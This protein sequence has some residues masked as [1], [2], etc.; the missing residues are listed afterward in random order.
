MISPHRFGPCSQVEPSGVSSEGA[1][2]ADTFESQLT[3]EPQ[4]LPDM[5]SGWDDPG[6]DPVTIPKA[7]PPKLERPVLFV[8]GYNSSA[9]RWGNMMGWLTSGEEPLNHSGGTID[10][11]KP[12]PVDP[13]ANLFSLKFSRPYNSVETNKE[14]LKKAVEAVVAA[15]GADEVDLVVH[16]MGGLDSRAYL[17]DE[18]EKVNKLVMLGTPN[19]GAQLA[20]LELFV[21][22]RIGIPTNPPLDDDEIRRALSQLSVDK[23]DRNGEPTNPWLHELNENWDKQ[24]EAADIMIIASTGIPTLSDGKGMS[25]LGDGT[26]T[27]K[28]AEMDGVE[29]KTVWFRGHG[30]IQN[31]GKVMENVALF[32]TDSAMDPGSDLFDSPED[33]LRAAALL[34]LEQSQQEELQTEQLGL[35]F[36]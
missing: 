11:A 29:N 32:L 10:A 16:S 17:E 34:H 25:A 14:E 5:S 33:K 24:K 13:E 26:V 8:H 9:D 7:K 6:S 36:S 3:P 30:S 28:S 19:H 22:E 20:N 1:L 2:P 27:R 15:T 35:I 12:G 4:F 21:R 23:L 31:S 18:D